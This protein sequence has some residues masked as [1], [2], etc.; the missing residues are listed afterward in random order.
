MDRRALAR[1][2][3]AFS[4][5]LLTALLVGCVPQG[6]AAPV[7]TATPS[8]TSSTSAPTATPS[9]TTTPT[10]TAP[11]AT[12]A[13]PVG[14][15]CE[16]LLTLQGVYDLNP[17]LSI[18][19]NATPPAG[20]LAATLVSGLGIACDLVH[21]SNGEILRVAAATPGSDAIAA[22][23]AGAPS[24]LDLGAAGFEAF[25]MDNAVLAFRG[26]LVLSAQ[27]DSYFGAEELAA[28]LR[29]AI[30]TIG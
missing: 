30:A 11:P 16:T 6:P 22:L 17:N 25:S 20:T 24:P 28:A 27:A 13:A 26:D 23:R 18:V 4:A 7:T 21:N 2:T 15:T 14:Y 8:P 12:N 29:T 19:P 1:P 10:A 5:L 3:I 9:P